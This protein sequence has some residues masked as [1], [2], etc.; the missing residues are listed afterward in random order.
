VL[1]DRCPVCLHVCLSCLPVTLVMY[2]GQR[3]GWMKMKLGTQ[4]GLGPG[5]IVLD[6]H[7]APPPQRGTAPI[8][9]PY[10]LRPNGCMDQDATSYRGRSKHTRLCVRRGPY[11]SRVGLKTADHR[12]PPQTSTGRTAEHTAGRGK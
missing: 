10:L 9:G 7:P 8:F 5:H 1:S 11:R 3:V 12:R 4:I 6:G 2:C